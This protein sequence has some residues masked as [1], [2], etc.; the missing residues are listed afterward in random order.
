MPVHY[1][2]IIKNKKH[3]FG[4]HINIWQDQDHHQQHHCHHHHQRHCHCHLDHVLSFSTSS[5]VERPL[6]SGLE[7]LEVSALRSCFSSSRDLSGWLSLSFSSPLPTSPTQFVWQCLKVD[8]PS[9]WVSE[10]SWQRLRR[11]WGLGGR[12]AQIRS[13]HQ[14]GAGAQ[15]MMEQDM[16]EQV[17]DL[18]CFDQSYR[19]SYGT[20][21]TS[22][23]SRHVARLLVEQVGW[24]TRLKKK[25][26][27]KG[28]FEQVNQW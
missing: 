10:W 4:W 27:T 14:T 8:C 5:G 11:L 3:D 16:L 7:P 26:G 25:L 28:S 6:R 23:R 22:T 2:I 17:A 18:Q 21:D 12:Q 15:A 1:F 13:F 20:S 24:G 19:T 9:V